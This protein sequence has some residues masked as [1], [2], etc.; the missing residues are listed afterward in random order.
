MEEPW[1]NG[2]QTYSAQPEGDAVQV[3]VDVL[4]R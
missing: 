4:A 2:S 3:A 1:V